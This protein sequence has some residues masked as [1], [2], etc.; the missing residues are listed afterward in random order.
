MRGLTDS[1]RQ[2]QDKPATAGFVV[3]GAGE[4]GK[5]LCPRGGFEGRA[6][7]RIAPA[8]RRAGVAVGDRI[9]LSANEKATLAVAFSFS[10]MARL[11]RGPVLQHRHARAR[12]G[13]RETLLADAGECLRE[14]GIHGRHVLERGRED[15]GVTLRKLWLVHHVR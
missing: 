15:R 6:V 12:P 2:I 4:P 9:L 5:L 14:V 3:S 7:A 1:L 13:L 11:V 8:R 10:R